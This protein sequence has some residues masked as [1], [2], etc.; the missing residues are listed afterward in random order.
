MFGFL[1][2]KPS[3]QRVS[4]RAAIQALLDVYKD[5]ADTAKLFSGAKRNWHSDNGFRKNIADKA[6]YEVSNNSYL[7][8]MV[9]TRQVD[10]V[11][12]GPK[13]NVISDDNDAAT[14][15]E[16]KFHQWCRDIGL[17][18]KLRAMIA[19][20][21]VTGEAFG[22]ITSRSSGP[23]PVKLDFRPLDPDQI[24]DHTNPKNNV[25]GN[26]HILDGIEYDS[27]GVPLA[28]YIHTS[29]PRVD[30]TGYSQAD[31]EKV[32]ASYVV[33]LFSQD[34]AT[35]VRGYSE[36]GPALLP[37]AQL[38]SFTNAVVKGANIAASLTFLL[39]TDNV[40]MDGEATSCEPYDV[41]DLEHGSGMA[42][43]DGWKATQF[44][45]E[46]P[47]DTYSD[48][49]N[50]MLNEV[51]RARLMPRLKIS[52]DA[53]A[54]N[55]SS[56]RMDGQEWWHSI[57]VDRCQVADDLLC[58][59]FQH[60]WSEAIT[61]TVDDVPYLSEGARA[62]VQPGQYPSMPKHRWGWDARPHVDPLKESK[63][64]ETQLMSG[65]IGLHELYARRNLD[66]E[67]ELTKAARVLNIDPDEYKQMIVQKLYG[68]QS[69]GTQESAGDED[70]DV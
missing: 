13:L 10:L 20:W 37:A 65:V 18:K 51:G 30:D 19:E 53:S 2:K 6:W 63:A 27:A 12:T 32:D 60:W 1:K 8:G 59:L 56:G 16:D 55:Y 9:R 17:H 67:A 29:H 66:A 54:Y 15:V 26:R 3:V 22:M 64:D 69:N 24:A 14:E 7:K 34:R 61:A 36:L 47:V 70:A 68:G 33:H 40:P 48:F 52:G 23:N 31:Y 58:K 43:P 45:A 42:L 62:L 49:K 4:Q 11:G 39:H 38:R 35:Q 46:Q 41:L 44:K 57:D 25:Q 28:Y 50:E 21:D 5:T